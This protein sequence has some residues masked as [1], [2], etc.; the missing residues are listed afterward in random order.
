MNDLEYSGFE[1]TVISKCSGVCQDQPN[2][3]CKNTI[4][5]NA[6][7]KQVY[8][9]NDDTIIFNSSNMRPEHS[10]DYNILCSECSIN[11]Q[12]YPIDDN[13]GKSYSVIKF[14]QIKL[15]TFM[16]IQKD[17]KL[18][19]QCSGIHIIIEPTEDEF[20]NETGKILLTY[21][22]FKNTDIFFTT[23]CVKIKDSSEKITYKTPSQILL[24]KKLI[25]YSKICHEL[26]DEVEQFLKRHNA[27][28]CIQKA[29]RARLT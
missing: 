10:K 7:R 28:L 5:R 19:M 25:Q 4:I 23:K 8:W 13:T 18:L 11:P 26:A 9:D 15:E 2:N 21:T 22:V 1:Y 6:Y 12:K 29:V 27:V 20:E 3:R 17:P 16:Q 24:D 14:G